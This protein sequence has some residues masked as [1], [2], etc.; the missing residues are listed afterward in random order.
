MDTLSNF[1][2]Y[3][4]VHPSV[5]KF[6]PWSE[7]FIEI[8]LAALFSIGFV[9]WSQTIVEAG[10]LIC[11]PT[12]GNTADFSLSE[13]RFVSSNCQ[14]EF[15]PRMLIFYPYYILLNFGI[16]LICHVLWSKIPSVVTKLST[17]C[18]LFQQI[19]K[20]TPIFPKNSPNNR[21]LPTFDHN[22]HAK[23]KVK[24][25]H[26]RI[27]FMLLE[28]STVMKIYIKKCRLMSVTCILSIF[29]TILWIWLSNF[30]NTTYKCV[31]NQKNVAKDLGEFSCDISPCIYIFGVMIFHLFCLLMIFILSLHATF[32][33]VKF[34]SNLD[35]FSSDENYDRFKGLPGI[36]DFVFCVAL[37]RTNFPDG[38]YTFHSLK[39]VLTQCQTPEITININKQSDVKLFLYEDDPDIMKKKERQLNR[40]HK[41]D[42]GVLVVR[43]MLYELGLNEIPN[44]QNKSHLYN[45]LSYIAKQYNLQ[46][47]SLNIEFFNQD[48]REII[49][50]E[51]IDNRLFYKYFNI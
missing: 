32:F 5:Q 40:L 12:I 6:K 49:V 47:D 22:E 37:L 36:Q 34:K 17:Y 46:S 25:L 29:V 44:Q 28:K 45:C 50:K 3:T 20:L 8:L 14:M 48:I 38:L 15:E 9:A 43:F 1:Q 21:V 11:V 10:G 42:E 19:S 2:K 4:S 30:G 31:L 13:S 18:S 33:S 39:Y 16:L 26:E 27:L 23:E 41:F 7:L 51:L 35:V 24:M